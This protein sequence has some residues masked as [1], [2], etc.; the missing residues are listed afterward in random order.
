MRVTVQCGAAGCS[1]RLSFDEAHR[2]ANGF[3][4][5]DC[6]SCRQR[7][8]LRGGAL[9]SLQVLDHGPGLRSVPAPS[10]AAGGHGRGP[11]ALGER[12]RR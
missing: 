6:G 12:A 11:A 3:L 7:F 4:I 8:V 10:A 5:A 2:V 1:G 9:A